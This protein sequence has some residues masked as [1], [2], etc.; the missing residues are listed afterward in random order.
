MVLAAIPTPTQN[1]TIMG[2]TE[3]IMLA[4]FRTLPN[5]ILS[6][7]TKFPHKDNN[8]KQTIQP[9]ITLLS[10]TSHTVRTF[11]NHPTLNI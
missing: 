2:P 4:L 9:H 8:S 3:H 1:I 10:K 6:L 5:I 11:L 7:R